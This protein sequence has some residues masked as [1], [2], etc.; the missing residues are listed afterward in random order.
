MHSP[1]ACPHAQLQGQPAGPLPRDMQAGLH[2]MS[3]RTLETYTQTHSHS[4][5][6]ADLHTPAPTPSFRI[7]A[8]CCQ[9]PLCTSPLIFRRKNQPC[10]LFSPVFRAHASH[11]PRSRS[12]VC[13]TKRIFCVTLVQRWRVKLLG[14]LLVCFTL[15]TRESVSIG[16]GVGRR[17]RRR[18]PAAQRPHART[19]AVATPFHP[20]QSLIALSPWLCAAA[21]SQLRKLRGQADPAQLQRRAGSASPSMETLSGATPTA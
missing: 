16:G 21:G 5:P 19:A 17:C 1:A 12:S 10:I 8:H 15:P 9:L 13:R 20:C 3:P 11:V 14:A 18:G 4:C 7:C 6:A 2:S